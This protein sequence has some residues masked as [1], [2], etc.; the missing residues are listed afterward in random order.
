MAALVAKSDTKAVADWLQADLSADLRP[1]LRKSSVPF[2][3]VM[4]YAQPYPYA[5]SDTLAFYKQMLGGVPTAQVLELT[6]ARH[7]AMLDQPDKFD[8]MLAQF[9]SAIH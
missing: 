6:P 5:E 2:L 3:E 9:L 4:P 1:Q 7:Y 8:A